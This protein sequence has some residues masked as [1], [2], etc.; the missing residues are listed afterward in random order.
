MAPEQVHSSVHNLYR[1]AQDI[2]SGF[3]S[4]T[5]LSDKQRKFFVKIGSVWQPNSLKTSCFFSK[6]S[7]VWTFELKWLLTVQ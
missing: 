6:V 4:N 7:A 3:F 5:R 1:K 2:F